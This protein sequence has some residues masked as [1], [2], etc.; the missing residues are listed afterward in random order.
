MSS[1]HDTAEPYS[2]VDRTRRSHI[3]Q[4][5][6]HSGAIFSIGQDTAEPYSA[7]DRTQW[8]ILTENLKKIITCSQGYIM[9]LFRFREVYYW[10]S[11]WTIKGLLL[12]ELYNTT[13][14]MLRNFKVQS[15]L[16]SL[17]KFNLLSK[18]VCR[19]GAVV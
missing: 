3:Q 17:N 19:G 18:A 7:V 14:G 4:W 15:R 10:D 16:T 8:S 2:A 9:L 6:G 1:G 13:E 5:T 11:Y 12:S